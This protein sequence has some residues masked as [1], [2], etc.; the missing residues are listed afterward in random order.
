MVGVEDALQFCFGNFCTQREE[1]NLVLTRSCS[2][3]HSLEAERFLAARAARCGL[4]TKV[5]HGPILQDKQRI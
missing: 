2:M 3:E 1:K 5:Q 4:G